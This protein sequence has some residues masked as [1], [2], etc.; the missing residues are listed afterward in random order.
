MT[1]KKLQEVILLLFLLARGTKTKI[2]KVGKNRTTIIS[3]NTI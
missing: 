2:V 1:L 3:N